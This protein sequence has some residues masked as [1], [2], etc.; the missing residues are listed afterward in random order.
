MRKTTTLQISDELYELIRQEAFRLRVSQAEIFRKAI[1][2]YFE[3]QEV[4]SHESVT[5]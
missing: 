1:L 3:T 2:L 5:L 4:V